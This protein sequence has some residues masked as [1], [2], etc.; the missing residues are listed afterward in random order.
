VPHGLGLGTGAWRE[1]EFELGHH[2]LKLLMRVLVLLR[3]VPKGE[4]SREQRA[5]R[6]GTRPWGARGGTMTKLPLMV[7]RGVGC[8]Q[9]L[10]YSK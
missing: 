2:H 1:E 5:R 9:Q 7:P 6:Y 8:G 10:S 4:P 3:I